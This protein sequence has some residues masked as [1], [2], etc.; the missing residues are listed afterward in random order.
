[1]Q[2]GSALPFCSKSRE[3]PPPMGKQYAILRVQKCKG[4][5]IGAMQYHRPNIYVTCDV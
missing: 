3:V 4:A 5:E 1:M 2:K